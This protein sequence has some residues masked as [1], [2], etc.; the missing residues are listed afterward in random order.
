M[1]L[2]SDENEKVIS[3]KTIKYKV[4][5]EVVRH[6][7]IGL[8]QNFARAIKELISNSYDAKALE[9]RIR[10]NLDEKSII[11]RDDGNGMTAQD[12]EDRLFNLAYPKFDTNREPDELGRL[13]VG[14]FGI[15]FVS[16]YPYCKKVQLITKKKDSTEMSEIE[17]ET[18]KFYSGGKLELSNIPIQLKVVENDL[19]YDK[20]ETII[21]LE[22][23]GEQHL[24]DLSREEEGR[25]SIDKLSGYEK[26]KWTICQYAPL[27]FPPERSDLRKMF[28]SMYG[29]PMR[30][31]LDGEELFRNVPDQA[32]ILEAREESV[33]GLRF[34]YA[35]MTPY[36]PIEPEEAR[37]LQ[38]RYRNVGIGFPNDLDVVKLTGA[39]LGKIN[40]L[41]GE[42]HVLS[43]LS[44]YVLIDRDRL[45][46]TREIQD[47]YEYFRKKLKDYSWEIEELA[48]KE[49]PV[50]ESLSKLKEKDQILQ[51]LKK[52][53]AVHFDSG[54]IRTNSNAPRKKQNY[55]P[56]SP[57]E[58]T[59]GVLNDKGFKVVLKGKPDSP[60]TPPIKVIP[61]EKTILIYEK[62]TEISEKIKVFEKE[63]QV[64]YGQWDVT[65]STNPA[66]KVDGQLVL[67]NLKHPLLSVANLVEDIKKMVLSV[68]V[69]SQ[70]LPENNSK[71]VTDTFYRIMT[72]VFL[73]E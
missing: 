34:K 29:K 31:W 3:T 40:Y 20:G 73:K 17:I 55:K 41:C 56:S 66:C 65:E 42:I 61:E 48:K 10:L 39:N 22:G 33:G 30:L 15:G 49:K 63:Y 62:H 11:I 59:A 51:E 26:F 38:I 43:D 54:R 6:L 12:V 5:Q 67:F 47:F 1:I 45:S 64:E 8:Y 52:A 32:Q 19:P 23:I 53:G 9:T 35:L 57:V 28:D 58:K 69:L 14:A 36:K 27:Q 44:N 70:T 46:Y 71:L 60:D 68:Q 16:I 2:L 4:N 50:Y 18:S 21:R 37:G 7:S 72:E 24:N 25:A 13:K